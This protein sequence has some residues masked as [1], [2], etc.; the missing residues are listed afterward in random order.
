M[1]DITRHKLLQSR[2][3]DLIEQQGDKRVDGVILR[4]PNAEIAAL[5]R[6]CDREVP[7]RYL[8][9]EELAEKTCE[10]FEEDVKKRLGQA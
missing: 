5:Y 9:P 8:S 2:I 6:M 7:D 4:L 1:A 3:I 10:R